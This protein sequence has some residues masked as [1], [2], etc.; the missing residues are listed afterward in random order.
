MKEYGDKVRLIYKN[1][2]LPFHKWAEPAAIGGE[3]VFDQNEEAF[4]TLYDY[5]F[6]HQREITPENVK[7]KVLEALKDTKVD[8]AKVTACLDGKQTAE[9]VQADMAEGQQAGVTGTPAF[10]INGRKISGAQPFESFK[11]VID[12]ELKRAGQKN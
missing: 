4:W 12:D 11:T 3:C 7:E 6:A 1:Y 10:L 5:L 2:P 9:R 8:T